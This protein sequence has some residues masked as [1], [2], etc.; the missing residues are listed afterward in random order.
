MLD[1]N[2]SYRVDG[3]EYD[4]AWLIQHGLSLPPMKAESS[5]MIEVKVA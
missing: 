1:P 3:A 5:L 4:G 2:C